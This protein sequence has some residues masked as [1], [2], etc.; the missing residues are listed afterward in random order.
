MISLWE[1]LGKK[2]EESGSVRWDLFLELKE[3]GGIFIG[4]GS[5]VGAHFRIFWMV[6]NDFY[7]GS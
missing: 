7:C 2:E 3:K 6:V 4:S 1:A 5:G